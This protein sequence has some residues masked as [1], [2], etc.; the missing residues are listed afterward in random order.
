MKVISA[1]YD[2]QKNAAPKAPGDINRILKQNFDAQII[3]LLRKKNYKYRL[4]L[5]FAKCAFYKGVI[6]LQHPLLFNP[7]AYD[8]LPRDRTVILIH[9]ISGLRN[10]DDVALAKE[11]AIFNKFKYIIVHNQRM[12]DFLVQQGVNEQNLYILEI[13]DYLADV[14]DRALP[15]GEPLRVIYPGNLRA[16]KTPFIYQLQEEKMDFVINLYGLGIDSDVCAKMPY[17]GSFEP[18]D[19]SV[20][21][22]DMGLIWDGDFD[23]G[24]EDKHFKNYTRYND[25]HKLSCCLAAGKPVIVWRKAAIADFV[26]EH[27]VGYTIGNIYDINAL[28][29]SD[30]EVKKQNARLLGAKLREGHYT[31]KVLRDI[32][33]KIEK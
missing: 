16:N 14:T 25:P 28:D 32:M 7:K 24:D 8:L 1:I 20:L 4:L 3:T 33:S 10:Q 15:T 18:D 22:G 19:I 27:N 2:E 5:E 6:V 21:Q 12:K 23:E 29:L 26:R 30:L 9:D 13:F 11:V 17:M 31:L